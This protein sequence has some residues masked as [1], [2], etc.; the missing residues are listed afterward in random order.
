MILDSL[1]KILPR[2]Q[3]S[4]TLFVF[5]M[6]LVI[7]RAEDSIYHPITFKRHRKT[8]QT[9][10]APLNPHQEDLVFGLIA[11]HKKRQLVEREFK[12]ILN[13]IHVNHHKAI[14]LTAQLTIDHPTINFVNRRLEEIELLGLNFKPFFPNL[15]S[16]TF[17]NISNYFGTSP[18]FKEG[19]IF[20]NG[21]SNP[22]GEILKLFLERSSYCPKKVIFI[23]D[24]AENVLS[25]KK[26]MDALNIPFEGWHYQGV[27][28]EEIPDFEANLVHEAWK[29]LIDKAHQLLEQAFKL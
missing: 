20:S 18:L 17:A 28:K 8:L 12:N 10:F 26:T 27:F 29:A 5:D 1:R 4:D 9:L 21:H 24:I 16:F 13:E 22:K 2:E 6:D 7:S 15:H 23:D 11:A 19:V 14:V 25:V 3:P